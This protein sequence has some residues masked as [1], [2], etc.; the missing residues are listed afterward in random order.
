MIQRRI[1]CSHFMRF[2]RD[3]CVLALH[4]IVATV[5]VAQCSNFIF[6]SLKPILEIFISRES[7]I[8]DFPLLLPLFPLQAAAGLV[9]GSLIA[10]K[11]ARF[12]R[13]WVARYVWVF[14]ALWFSVLFWA[15]GPERWNFFVWSADL[16]AKKIQ[17][18]STLPLVAS[19]AYSIGSYLGNYNRGK[20]G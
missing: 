9:I 15:R 3:T 4:S 2:A 11:S 20:G 19:V 6:Y 8:H 12:G 16:P 17:L 10:L 18:V 13:M 14:P 7:L 1:C 5:G